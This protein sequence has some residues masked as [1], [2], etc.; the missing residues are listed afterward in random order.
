MSVLS[1]LVLRLEVILLLSRSFGS[2]ATLHKSRAVRNLHGVGFAPNQQGLGGMRGLRRN[3]RRFRLPV[4]PAA[5]IP[6]RSSLPAGQFCSEG[7]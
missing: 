6:L 2:Q 4:F 7:R 1:D 3:V 5:R